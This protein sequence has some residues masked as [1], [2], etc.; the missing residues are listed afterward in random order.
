[1]DNINQELRDR[2]DGSQMEQARERAI[3]AFFSLGE[4]LK[5]FYSRDKER[6]QSKIDAQA[7]SGTIEGEIIPRL[8]LA[9][10]RDARAKKLT[11]PEE[12]GLSQSDHEGFLEAVMNENAAAARNYVDALVKRGLSREALFLN[13][14]TNT[15]RRLGEMW[16]EDLCDFTDVTI[17]LCRLHEILRAQSTVLDAGAGIRKG[18]DSD[19]SKILLATA[20]GD[21]HVFGVVMVAEFFRRAGWRVSC[22]PGAASAELQ[23]MLSKKSFD[24]VGL[25]AARSV[26]ADDIADEIADLRSA[27]RNEAVMIMVGGRLFAENP[28][29]VSAV[30]AD[31][32]A[33]DAKMAPM[34]GAE[35]LASSQPRC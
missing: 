34:I 4:K 1:M 17:G 5:S 23:S 7:L 9:Y 16:E 12:D 29:L 35:L 8:L 24:M 20:C 27:S 26:T 25:S 33:H 31:G 28:E 3:S 21:Q 13:L 6:K 10:Q 2:F 22:E 14:L 30:G 11:T 18:A 32:A 15:A 19:G